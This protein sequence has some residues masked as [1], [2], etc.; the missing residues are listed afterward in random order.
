MPMINIIAKKS[1]LVWKSQSK[2]SPIRTDIAIDETTIQ[3]APKAMPILR[4]SEV[5]FL[6]SFSI[7]INTK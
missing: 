1:L 6:L 5:L 4:H 2:P 7:K 3:L